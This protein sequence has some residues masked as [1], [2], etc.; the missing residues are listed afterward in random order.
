MIK[1]NEKN[2]IFYHKLLVYWN[3]IEYF[4]SINNFYLR[5]LYK[6]LMR[7]DINVICNGVYE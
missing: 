1:K 4:N 7:I 6:A 3:L 2:E 5:D